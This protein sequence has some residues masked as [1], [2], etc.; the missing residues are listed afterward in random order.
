MS[1]MHVHQQWGAVFFS[2]LA[3]LAIAAVYLR[4]WLRLRSAPGNPI[5]AWRGA[6]F[7]TGLLALWAAACSPLATLDHRSLTVHM[8]KH[9]TI[10][11]VTA[12]LVLAGMPS[13]PLL[14]GLPIRLSRSILPLGQ[15]PVRSVAR[16]ITHPVFCW[17]VG[18]ATVIVWH[19][20]AVF[21][22]GQ[23]SHWIHGLEDTSFFLAGLLFWWPVVQT[24]RGVLSGRDWSTPLYLFLATLP[25]D[26]LSAF[27]VFCNRVVYSGYT[28][29]NQVFGWSP[30][31]DQ[32]CA[33]ALMWVWV[34]FAYLIPA[35]V[36][37]VQMLSAREGTDLPVRAGF[38]SRCCNSRQVEVL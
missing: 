27:L 29:G 36:I 28:V 22:L 21:G 32:E 33:G 38:A 23:Q 24:R 20:P 37:T 13:L 12:P 6:A 4:G 19:L 2:S 30:S 26:I 31:Q 35:A 17:V 11:T 15:S 7:L 3:L 1:V 25:C 8:L 18:T 9:L 5:S 16:F 14:Y 34:T 10:M